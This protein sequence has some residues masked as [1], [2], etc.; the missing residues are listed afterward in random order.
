MKDNEKLMNA[1]AE[2]LQQNMNNRLT[3]QLCN[4]ILMNIEQIII[5]ASK[6]TEPAREEVKA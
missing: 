3:V 5:K 4:G 2:V 1:I 6:T